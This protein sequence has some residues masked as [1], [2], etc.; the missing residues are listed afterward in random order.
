MIETYEKG[1]SFEWNR[2]KNAFAADSEEKRPFKRLLSTTF[3]LIDQLYKTRM[4]RTRVFDPLKRR[5][6]KKMCQ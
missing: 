4:S 6:Q 1:G 5:I 3:H 2:K